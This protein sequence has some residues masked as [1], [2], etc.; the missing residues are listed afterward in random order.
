MNQDYM[1]F[2]AILNIAQQEVATKGVDRNVAIQTATESV[3]LM[4]SKAKELAAK[5]DSN[6]QQQ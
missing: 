3:D 6:V 4:L 2:N 1:I 5:Y